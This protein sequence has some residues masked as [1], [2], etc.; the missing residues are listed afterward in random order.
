ME[1]LERALG[2][3]VHRP[4]VFVFLAVYLWIA[5]AHLGWRRT[6]FLS[7]LAYAVAFVAEWSSTRNGFPFG[8]YVYFDE[9]FR[10]RELFVSNVPFWDSLSFSFLCYFGYTTALTLVAPLEGRGITATRR[11]SPALARSFVVLL[12]SSFFTALV[13]IAIDPVTLLGDRWFLGRIYEYGQHG[14]YFGVPLS[15]FAGWFLVAFVT[16]GIFQRVDPRL[17]P[18]GRAADGRPAQPHRRLA[19]SAFVGPIVYVGVYAFVIAITFSIGEMTI[20]YASCFLLL[21][22][23]I[24]YLGSIWSRLRPGGLVER[25]Q[26][27]AESPAISSARDASSSS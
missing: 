14:H 12:I 7:L 6:V 2:T 8:F 15:N 5:S 21:A 19:A 25:P 4:Y 1:F 3:L 13:D 16:I 27:S 9:A 17:G 20:A 23:S 10:E 18:G 11:E 22:W 24:P 26:D